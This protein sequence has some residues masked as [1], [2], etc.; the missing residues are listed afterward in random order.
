MS[1]E[2]GFFRMDRR[3]FLKRSGLAALLPLWPRRLFASKGLRRRHPSDADWPSKAA[4]KR[5]NDDADGNLIPVDFPNQACIRD[6]DGVECKNLMAASK[7][8]ATSAIS[9]D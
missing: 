1:R 6:V 8:R 4:W 3:R 7:I 5:L 2:E 9:Q